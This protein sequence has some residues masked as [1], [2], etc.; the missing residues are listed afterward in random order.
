MTTAATRESEVGRPSDE[1]HRLAELIQSKGD[2][3]LKKFM[4][5]LEKSSNQGNQP[6]HQKLLQIL[7]CDLKVEHAMAQGQHDA[8]NGEQATTEEH[9]S[10]KQQTDEGSRLRQRSHPKDS[11]SSSSS[12][13]EASSHSKS[14]TT[15][16]SEVNK[17]FRRLFD[18]V[19]HRLF[20][21]YFENTPRILVVYLLIAVLLYQHGL[22]VLISICDKNGF[23]DLFRNID[24]NTYNEIMYRILKYA[25]RVGIIVVTSIFFMR[26]LDTLAEKPIVPQFKLTLQQTQDWICR[27]Y[28]QRKDVMDS[29]DLLVAFSKLENMI[30][31]NI[32][33][34]LW[35]VFLHA[36]LLTTLLYWI[37]AFNLD[38]EVIVIG[39]VCDYLH[40]D[41][42]LPLVMEYVSI[43]T[44]ILVV[45]IVKEC[46]CYE[47][48]VAAYAVLIGKEGEELYTEIRK[49]WKFLDSYCY[50]T[51]FVLFVIAVLSYSTGKNFIPEPNHG[52]E[53]TDVIGWYFW[54]VV[55]SAISFLAS[56]PKQ[57]TAYLMGYLVCLVF[58]LL[59]NG[60]VIPGTGDHAIFLMYIILA[61]LNFNLIF[62]LY[63]C[64]SNHYNQTQDSASWYKKL[65]CLLW[66][67]LLPVLV[68][69]LASREYAPLLSSLY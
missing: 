33:S 63:R 36:V 68:I 44:V 60:S 17:L 43:C 22:L 37:G 38:E 51:P 40:H 8:E 13:A 50:I 67:G 4:S 23:P 3:G 26:Q 58:V 30:K 47:N 15:P 49:R 42:S 34:S 46:Y 24:E 21:D 35:M 41:F 64:N 25:L 65:L 27:I 56:S 69:A 18:T 6:G 11:D 7:E 10:V 52:M 12:R 39:G 45:G 14:T 48:R 62:T 53:S 54:T 55:L 1:V 28:T 57:S 2:E 16:P 29:S 9:A 59:G 20:Q 19:P 5:A 31:H 66:M 32:M 61:V